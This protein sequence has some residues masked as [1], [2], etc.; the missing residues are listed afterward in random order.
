MTSL[1]SI[2]IVDDEP[3]LTNQL[4]TIL[5][6][7]GYDVLTAADG[8]DALPI[9]SDSSVDLIISDV[10]MPGM[11]GYQFLT[12]LRQDPAQVGIPVIFLSARG[13]DSDIRFGK[14]LGVDDY[15]VKPITADDLLAAVRGRL[16]RASQMAAY[17]GSTQ[18][19]AGQAVQVGPLK[20]D[21]E[22]HQVE[23]GKTELTLSPREFRLLSMLA[24]RPEHPFSPEDLVR[25]THEFDTDAF[26]AGNLI[27]PLIRSLRIKVEEP[28]QGRLQ[29]ENVRG[30]GYRLIAS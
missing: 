12:T 21:H 7:E 11:N 30:V 27:R 19:A 8:R 24:T 15:L 5:E 9:I 10:S 26:E 4:S 20:I 1:A 2:L 17:A 14:E 23:V 29:I 18:P 13:M 6:L 22:R 16:L 25:C 3:A 28:S